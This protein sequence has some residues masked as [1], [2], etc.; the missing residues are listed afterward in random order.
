MEDIKL[1]RKQKAFA[2][3]LIE[4]PTISQ[5]EAAR[6]VYDI[7]NPQSASALGAKVA[8]NTKVLA[9]MDKN[10]IYAEKA[11]VQVLKNAKK[12]K[13]EHQW[14]RLALDSANSVLDRVH[15]KATQRVESHSTVVTLGLSL[16]DIIE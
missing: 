8:H 14:Q 12:N 9:Y 11:V 15:G 1:T 4:N 6:Q 16:T 3:L 10:A 7:E 13:G 2:N 5:A